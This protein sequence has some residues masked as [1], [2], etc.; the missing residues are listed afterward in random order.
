MLSRWHGIDVS[1]GTNSLDAP[2]IASWGV[3]FSFGGSFYKIFLHLLS[4]SFKLKLFYLGMIDPISDSS[5]LYLVCSVLL[6]DE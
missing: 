5:P 4:D 2:V 3:P 1:E 6:K